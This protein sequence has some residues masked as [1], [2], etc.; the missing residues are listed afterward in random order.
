MIHLVP[1]PGFGGSWPEGPGARA[2][3][4]APKPALCFLGLTAWELG[5]WQRLRV[6]STEGKSRKEN[7]G[8][9]RSSETIDLPG[10]D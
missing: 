8:Q 4:S 5:S 6:S 10:G 7:V 3:H 9:L 2:G 1:S